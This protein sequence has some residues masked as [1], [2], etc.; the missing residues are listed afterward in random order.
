MTDELRGS[1]PIYS[2]KDVLVKLDG[3]LDLID[4]KV[5]TL[6]QNVAIILSQNL[7]DRMTAVE[8][9]Q[10]RVIGM[11]SSARVLGV[12]STLLG[13]VAV[14]WQIIDKVGP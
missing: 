12:I 9:W 10:N 1:T 3:K 8:T 2:A 4:G 6:G 13:I 7:G 14:G 5:D 11:A